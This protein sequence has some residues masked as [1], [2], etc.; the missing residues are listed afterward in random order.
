[1]ILKDSFR[2]QNYYERLIDYAVSFLSLKNN[3]T[4]VAQEHMRSKTNP[5]AADEIIMLPKAMQFESN[6]ISVMD[7]VSFLIDICDEKNKLTAAIASAKSTAK[8]NIDSSIEMN[9]VRHRVST[10]LSYM[11]GIKGSQTI[12][13]GTGNKF[14]GE[15]NQVSYVYDVKEVT[16]IDFD[17]NK[18]KAMAKKLNELSDRTSAEIDMANITIDVN[19]TPK[20]DLDDSFED[21]VLKF[22]GK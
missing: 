1:M 21:C 19:Y 17:R 12:K 13:T 7:V 6:D 9:K 4:S 11:S 5:D 18:V 16:T 20:Y 3:V 22:I 15:G 8:I 14:N 10:A 2:Y